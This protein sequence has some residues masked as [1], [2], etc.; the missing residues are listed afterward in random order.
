[1]ADLRHLEAQAVTHEVHC[2]AYGWGPLGPSPAVH[3][4]TGYALDGEPTDWPIGEHTSGDG[5]PGGDFRVHFGVDAVHD[6]PNVV[7][8]RSDIGENILAGPPPPPPARW[9]SPWSDAGP[10]VPP[11]GEAESDFVVQVL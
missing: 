3:D 4:L 2:P 10:T 1:M 5:A 9:R 11:G 6:T 7:A 8:E